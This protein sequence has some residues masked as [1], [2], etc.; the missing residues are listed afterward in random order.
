M[1]VRR[2]FFF[3]C[4]VAAGLLI[5]QTGRAQCLPLE[6]L[7]RSVATGL[8]NPDSLMNLMESGEWVMHR[9]PNPYWTHR[10]LGE[11]ETPEDRAQ[12]WVGLRRSNQQNYYDLVYKTR[13]RSCLTQLRTDLRRRAKLKSEPIYCVQCEGERL[14][15][16]G[17]I[18][19]IFYQKDNFQAKH[20]DYPYVLVIR[21]TI[22]GGGSKDKENVLPEI[23]S[24]FAGDR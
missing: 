17:Y 2:W 14:V 22:S 6:L 23:S 18:V 3:L 9:G 10:T 1:Q 16:E 5:S 15:G 4:V 20:T 12:A 11:A 19:S 13:Q 8:I 21:R 24:Q 7:D